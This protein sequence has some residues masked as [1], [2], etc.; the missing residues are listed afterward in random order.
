[1]NHVFIHAWVFI[2]IALI[3]PSIVGK[4]QEM[5]TDRPGETLSPSTV[6]AG[7][8]MME[9]GFVYEGDKM[10]DTRLH[11]ITP[12]SVLLR[13]GLINRLELRAGMAFFH[14]NYVNKGSSYHEFSYIEKGLY[15][16][17]FGLKLHI[18]D[19]D[20]I[21]PSLAVVGSLALPGLA[22]KRYAPD[23][24]APD[25]RI[26]ASHHLLPKVT[27]G[28]SIGYT[29]DGKNDLPAFDYSAILWVAH[30]MNLG[31]FYEIYG[32]I[33]PEAVAADVRFDAGLT[34][35]IVPTLQADLS[36]GIGITTYA[37]DFYAGV[38]FSWII[39]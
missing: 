26:A 1:M 8:L 29:W 24:I 23:H 15:P 7:R 27:T 2:F 9:A 36:G 12:L 25:I 17:F 14:K 11:N 3:Q 6:E 22:T 39:P 30:S 16:V 4:A 33:P 28:Y 38:G 32:F 20:G 19:N 18:L 10:E 37:P 34:W 21:I 31:S 13:Y 35:L 5:D